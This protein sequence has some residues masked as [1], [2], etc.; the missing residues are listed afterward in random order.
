[1]PPVIDCPFSASG[2]YRCETRLGAESFVQTD[3]GF[4]R[5][6]FYARGTQHLGDAL[7]WEL[8]N[9]IEDFL[10]HLLFQV[11]VEECQMSPAA[12]EIVFSEEWTP[13]PAVEV[14]T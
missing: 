9:M 13:G 3:D 14:Q 12:D 4:V 7:R 5:R 2:G 1:M 8:P 10:A 11:H 6:Q